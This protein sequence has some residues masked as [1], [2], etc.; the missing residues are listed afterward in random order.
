MNFS[1]D[2]VRATAAA[3]KRLL[4]NLKISHAL[5]E[6][7]WTKDGRKPTSVEKEWLRNR[8]KYM[9]ILQKDIDGI[10]AFLIRNDESLFNFTENSVSQ[11]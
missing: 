1:F 9:Q 6:L 11:E 10:H 7:E 3:E 2:K 4:E 8:E 5:L